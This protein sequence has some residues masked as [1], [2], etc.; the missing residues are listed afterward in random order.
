MHRLFLLFFLLF[1]STA[2]AEVLDKMPALRAVIITCIFL[3]L[4]SFLA[5][6]YKPILLLI[7]TPIYLSLSYSQLSEIYDPSLSNAL[8]HEAGKSYIYSSWMGILIVSLAMLSGYILRLK[9]R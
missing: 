2:H 1:S 9:H 7:I 5:A 6:R 4:L 3:A 8:I